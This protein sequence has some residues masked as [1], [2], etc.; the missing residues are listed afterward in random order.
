MLPEEL[1]GVVAEVLQLP[2]PLL[3]QLTQLSLQGAL[4]VDVLAARVHAGAGHAP[5]ARGGPAAELSVHV[6]VGGEGNCKA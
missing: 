4:A 5:L 2:V 6:H 3:L 1:L